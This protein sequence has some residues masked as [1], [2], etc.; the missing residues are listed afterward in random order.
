[1]INRTH[2]RQRARFKELNDS[3]VVGE[4]RKRRSPPN[5]DRDN[6]RTAAYIAA[7]RA[8][9]EGQVESSQSDQSSKK[10]VTDP[11]SPALEHPEEREAISDSGEESDA[12]VTETFGGHDATINLQGKGLGILFEAARHIGPI[13]GVDEDVTHDCTSTTIVEDPDASAQAT[14]V[15]VTDIQGIA[16]DPIHDSTSVLATEEVNAIPRVEEGG[17][18]N[19][20]KIIANDG[21]TMEIDKLKARDEVSDKEEDISPDVT[22]DKPLS[23]EDLQFCHEVADSAADKINGMWQDA[24]TGGKFMYA[25]VNENE[26]VHPLA[27]MAAG[28]NRGGGAHAMLGSVEKHHD[29]SPDVTSDEAMRDMANE[30]ECLNQHSMAAAAD[31]SASGVEPETSPAT[32][33]EKEASKGFWGR[34]RRALI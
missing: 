4:T 11:G 1:M 23:L 2:E 29:N 13:A 18:G 22:D 15:V 27:M 8:E 17:D 30:I 21:A 16:D 20:H 31:I 28:E 7:C 3:L 33:T 25:A 32:M 14:R 24:L 12:T 10:V 19:A 34:V 26:S 5:F 9:R 6:P